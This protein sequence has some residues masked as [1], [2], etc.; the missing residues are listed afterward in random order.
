MTTI[1]ITGGIGAGKSVVSRV[2]RALGYPVYDSDTAARHLVD[3][4]TD[5]HA[6]LCRDIHPAAVVDG[7]VDR[8]LI[9]S[10]VFADADALQRLNSIV[11]PRLVDD[12]V[13][14][15]RHHSGATHI[16]IETAIL[17]TCLPL[18]PHIDAIWQVEAPDDLR[19]ARVVA[20]SHLTPAQVRARI[21]AQH[22]PV[23]AT[24]AAIPRH[25]IL[26]D[27]RTPLLPRIHTLL[28]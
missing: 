12:F 11:H 18:H 13:T 15:A 5:I 27:L 1:A 24:L 10:V 3:S 17:D 22:T 2:L 19:V 6:C 25:T 14:W 23:A 7:R 21:A 20:R 9:S 26:N 8:P 28:H 4:D 16:F